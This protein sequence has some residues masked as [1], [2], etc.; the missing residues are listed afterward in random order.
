[1]EGIIDTANRAMVQN[2]RDFI[3]DGL[4]YCGVCGGKKQTR[5]FGS[6][7][8]RCNCACDEAEYK[9]MREMQR[10]REE[11]DRK[12]RIRSV[13]IQSQE[14]RGATFDSDDHANTVTNYLLQYAKNFAE[15]AADNKGLLLYGGVGS[16]KSFGA[17]CVANYLIDRGIAAMMTNFSAVLNALYAADDK[18][19][20]IS[21]FVS[22]PL[23]I[24]DD[25]GMER[26]TEYALEQ[27]FNVIDA[28]KR[29]GKP[30]IVTTNLSLGAIDSPTD[31]AHKRIYSRIREICCVAI[32]FGSID[33]RKGIADRKF[34][35][36]VHLLKGE[37]YGEIVTTQGCRRRA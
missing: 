20:L 24:L 25:F 34:K 30:L 4:I 11:A 9:K 18:N 15:M 7:I 17:A 36:S 27:V 1:M 2:E 35:E 14:Y 6:V 21:D 19:A 13:C 5:L 22:Y 33:R 10:E 31:M 32:D 29:T 37:R 23:L 26:Q 12:Q 28:R 3:Q 16:G 8:V